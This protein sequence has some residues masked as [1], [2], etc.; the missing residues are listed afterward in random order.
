M[1][2][3]TAVPCLFWSFLR[4]WYRCSLFL[5]KEFGSIFLFFIFILKFFTLKLL[6][7]AKQNF[8]WL[9]FDFTRFFFFFFNSIIVSVKKHDL[10]LSSRSSWGSLEGLVLE[11]VSSKFKSKYFLSNNR[12]SNLLSIREEQILI[13]RPLFK[14]ANK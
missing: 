14:D 3:R 13:N 9:V 2:G 5:S 12:N 7:F 11:T 8:K 1:T 10:M 4:S 6:M